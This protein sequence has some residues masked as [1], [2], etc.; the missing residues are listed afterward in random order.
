MSLKEEDKMTRGE[1]EQWAVQTLADAVIKGGF[2][3]LRMT[4]VY[5]V[6]QWAHRHYLSGGFKEE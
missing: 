6:W 1:F 5:E 4:F 2:Q 3:E